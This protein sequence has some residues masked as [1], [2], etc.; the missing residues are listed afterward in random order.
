MST[1]DGPYY[2]DMEKGQTF[3]APPAVV[4]DSGLASVYQSIAGEALPL[5]LDPKLCGE[6]TGI[7]QRIVSPGLL[8]HLSIGASTVAT[9]K[10]IANLFYRNV[11]ILRPVF[12]GEVIHTTTEVVALQDSRSTGKGT[13]RGKVLLKITTYANDEKVLEYYRAPLVRLKGTELPG[14]NDDLGSDI[15]LNLNDYKRSSYEDWKLPS[16]QKYEQHIPSGVIND[17]LK[18][19]VDQALALVRLT[20]NV[21]SVHRD[22]NASPYPNRLVYGGHTVAL[23]QAS[24]SRIFTNTA[25]ILGWHTCNHTG[26]V[27]EED[28]LSFEHEV[29]DKQEYASGNIIA[30]RSRVFVHRDNEEPQEVLEWIPIIL[31][32]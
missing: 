31:T 25:T 11:R 27:F 29:I 8:L 3:P 9:K 15:E 7:K 23:A 12:L 13:L 28:L 14:H 26:P 17:P 21:A 10:V 18:D 6:V 5:V 22:V 1:S 19:V 2:E 16:L 32:S 30:V 4:L 20:Q 24:L